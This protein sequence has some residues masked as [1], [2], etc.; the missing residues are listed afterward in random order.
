M[1]SAQGGDPNVC[2]DTTLLPQAKIVA[3]IRAESAG[4]LHRMDTT[5]LGYL[6]LRHGRGTR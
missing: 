4:S 1:I 5:R 2:S 6:A 3:D